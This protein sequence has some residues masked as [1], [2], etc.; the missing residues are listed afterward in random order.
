MPQT[1]VCLEIKS[2]YYNDDYYNKNILNICALPKN[3]E[4]IVFV[5]KKCYTKNIEKYDIHNIKYKFGKK[6]IDFY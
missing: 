4:T 3:L 1:L 6:N 2:K 5:N